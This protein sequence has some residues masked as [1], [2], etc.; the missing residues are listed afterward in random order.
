[1][2]VRVSLVR[3]R[4][5]DSCRGTLQRLSFAMSN[6]LNCFLIFVVLL[7][8]FLISLTFKPTNTSIFDSLS[9]QPPTWLLSDLAR[10]FLSSH[11][12]RP[13]SRQC[14]LSIPST[15][16]FLLTD[17][18]TSQNPDDIV[19]TLAIRTPL[20]KGKKGSFKDTELDYLVYALLKKV[21]E[22]SKIDPAQIE[23]VCLGNV[24]LS[25]RVSH[26]S[27]ID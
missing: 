8:R 9:H 19:I 1:M 17:N 26:T 22:K 11:Q 20:A 16:G 10:S 5:S 21:L 13:V 23:D 6:H 4:Q 3:Y 7:N 25:A 12:A 27:H 24:R 15:F 2:P 18:S 14:K